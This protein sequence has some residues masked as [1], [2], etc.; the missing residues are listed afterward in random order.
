MNDTLILAL[1]LVGPFLG[2]ATVYFILVRKDAPLLVCVFA[3]TVFLPLMVI[4]GL[5]WR[6]KSEPF[7]PTRRRALF[8]VFVLGAVSGL[9]A[10]TVQRQLQGWVEN[11]FLSRPVG[12]WNPV[13]R[14]YSATPTGARWEEPVEE[15]RSAGRRLV[16]DIIYAG[17]VEECAKLL[18]VLLALWWYGFPV[19]NHAFVYATAAALGFCLF[20]DT[21]RYFA[22]RANADRLFFIFAHP[23][24]CFGW[25]IGLGWAKG[26][27]H[28]SGGVVVLLGLLASA[29]VHGTHDF[30]VSAGGDG[31]R[32]LHYCLILLLWV[33]FAV[34]WV[35]FDRLDARAANALALQNANGALES[36][37]AISQ[38]VHFTSTDRQ[39]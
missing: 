34:L 38:D 23:A 25:V 19:R 31:P 6:R 11:A 20:E 32:H 7:N 16:G 4:Q 18:A 29:V 26:R 14:T 3:A 21:Y 8:A 5:N 22:E 15:P 39:V 12:W 17:G 2:L 24:M 13:A 10:L 37:A 33:S 1:T 28:V 30:L 27:S 35:V 36:N 9:L